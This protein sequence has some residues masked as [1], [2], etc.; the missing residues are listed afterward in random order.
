MRTVFG[1]CQSLFVVISLD[2]PWIS[3]CV[4]LNHIITL[5]SDQV[6]LT[7]ITLINSIGQKHVTS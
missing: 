1:V 5:A 2:E 4:Y 6:T 7:S 3:H